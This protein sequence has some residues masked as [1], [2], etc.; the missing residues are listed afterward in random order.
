MKKRLRNAFFMLAENFAIRPDFRILRQPF[1][2]HDHARI[3]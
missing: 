2:R 3:D 1:F